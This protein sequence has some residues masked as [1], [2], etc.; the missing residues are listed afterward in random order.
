MLDVADSQEDLERVIKTYNQLIMILKDRPID[1]TSSGWNLKYLK[2]F[3]LTT[4]FLEKLNKK[5]TNS[6]R[7]KRQKLLKFLETLKICPDLKYEEFNDLSKE[8]PEEV[9]YLKKY[10]KYKLKYQKLKMKI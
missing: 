3:K 8:N 1:F 10:L 5:I 2:K 9:P 6:H 7:G 4:Y